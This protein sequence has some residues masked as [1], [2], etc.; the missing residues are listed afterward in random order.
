[1]PDVFISYSRKD[2]AFVQVL[3]QAL[4]ESHYDSWVDW[5][6]IPL[7][8]DWWEE[9]KTG[10]EAADTFIF[11]ISPDSIESKVCRQE[12][13]HAVVYN[14]RLVPIVRR[15]GFDM[16]RV[17]PDLGKA[18]WLFFQTD[19]D[20]DMTFQTLVKTLNTDLAH[21]K[22]HTKL[23]VRALEWE[24]KDKTD[25]ILLRGG[26]LDDANRWLQQA[27]VAAK[28]PAPTPTQ[29]GF[30]QASQALADRLRQ[31]EQAEQ[32][33]QLRQAR[34][35]ALTAIVAG[36]IMTGLASFA[37]TQKR[38]VETVQESQINALSRYSLALTESDKSF[39]ALLEALRAGQQLRKQLNWADDN[40]HS[41]VLTALQAAVYEEGW[42]EQNR[43]T[44][45]TNDV[46]RLAISPDGQL[47][48]S[49]SRDHTVR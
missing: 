44:G 19:S 2:K 16:A 36:I 38:Q 23:L 35:A 17:H 34:R 46:N 26:E 6:D 37:F 30:I 7:T 41:H 47:I 39:D 5:E 24:H 45:H 20:F 13:D 42:R 1:M 4:L 12:I 11:V 21:V 31:Q 40:T 33:R 9:I 28:Q 32:Q 48:A 8:A 49:A 29:L 25:D 22:A 14:K 15:D 18:N 10:I 27:L 43:L 3:H